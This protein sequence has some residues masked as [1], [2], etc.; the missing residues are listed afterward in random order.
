VKGVEEVKSGYA[1]GSRDNAV[2]EEVKAGRTGH[3]EVIRILYDPS[4][5]S[6]TSNQFPMQ[7]FWTF[8]SLSTTLPSKTAKE[9]TLDLNTYRQFFISTKSK[10]I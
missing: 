3:H 9:K 6:F 4:I 2:Y 1:G 5:V 7:S 10:K 8:S